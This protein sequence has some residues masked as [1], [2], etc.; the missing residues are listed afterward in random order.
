MPSN[1]FRIAS[2]LEA[3]QTTMNCLLLNLD[4][5]P[6]CYAQNLHMKQNQSALSS[7]ANQAYLCSWQQKQAT[8]LWGTEC[9]WVLLRTDSAAMPVAASTRH[10]TRRSRAPSVIFCNVTD[11]ASRLPHAPEIIHRWKPPAL[12]WCAPVKGATDA[13]RAPRQFCFSFFFPLQCWQSD[14]VSSS[15]TAPFLCYPWS[16]S[17]IQ[18]NDCGR[19]WKSGNALATSNCGAPL[20]G[21]KWHVWPF[22]CH[23]LVRLTLCVAPTT[24][25]IEDHVRNH[26]KCY[27]IAMCWV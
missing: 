11:V 10:N 13:E 4:T 2:R 5:I 25:N 9:P 22:V 14:P 18:C 8:F 26:A 6:V 19:L 17:G 16:F 21:S 1:K 7:F 12:C 3:L 15:S 27:I 23:T 20:H 24:C